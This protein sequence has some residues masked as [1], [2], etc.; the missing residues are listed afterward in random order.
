MRKKKETVT[1]SMADMQK[2]LVESRI[3]H[4]LTLT[5]NEVELL[6]CRRG[7][8]L[9]IRRLLSPEEYSER[10]EVVAD[11]YAPVLSPFDCRPYESIAAKLRADIKGKRFFVA[12]CGNKD[13]CGLSLDVAYESNKKSKSKP[14]QR[15]SVDIDG[16][17]PIRSTDWN[18]LAREGW[19]NCDASGLTIKGFY[20]RLDKRRYEYDDGLRHYMIN[21]F[22]PSAYYENALTVIYRVYLHEAELPK[23]FMCPP[24]P[25]NWEDA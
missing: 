24:I 11:L 3:E 15:V 19:E 22:G 16:V 10:R 1:I 7:R 9:Y 2:L 17:A 25:N 8:L 20:G 5:P 18:Q 13:T 12:F 4:F 23:S 14:R 6:Q 21:K